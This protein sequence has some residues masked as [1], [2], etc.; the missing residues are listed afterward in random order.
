MKNLFL[1]SLLFVAFFSGTVLVLIVA[2]E[3]RTSSSKYYQ[4]PANVTTLIAGHSRP[5]CAF[6]DTVI[7]SSCNIS[8]VAEPYF[9]TYIKLRK[10]LAG[11]STIQTVL[12]EFSDNNINSGLM[13]KWLYGDG[14][15]MYLF[16]KYASIMTADEKS[17]LFKKDPVEYIKAMPVSLKS[18]I[19][20][21]MNRSVKAYEFK[22]MGKY[23]GK[24]GS[25]LE[26]LK[27]IPIDSLRPAPDSIAGLNLIYLDN[28]VALCRSQHIRIF[29]TRAPVH[30]L[31][32]TKAVEYTYDSIL[33]KRFPSVPLLDFSR[34]HLQDAD[35]CDFHH[36][37]YGGSVK[38][39]AAMDS[40]LKLA[41]AIPSS[42]L[43]HQWRIRIGQ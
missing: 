27:K 2:F 10:I 19:E 42:V 30:P 22:D 39:S 35:Y 6:N 43:E 24:S 15:L 33:N 23:G 12:V 41:V 3:Q 32:M 4:L 13:N 17:F 34:Y 14:A 16:P 26:N 5:G 25:F 38:V 31:F 20:F 28:I 21:M 29:F 8:S 11:N 37:N 9:Y 36:I 40:V 18:D 1:K 7:Q